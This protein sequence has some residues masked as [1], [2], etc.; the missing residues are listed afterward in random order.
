M[1]SKP[2]SEDIQ[3]KYL[4]RD[5]AWTEIQTKLV[6]PENNS[7][8]SGDKDSDQSY[9][10]EYFSENFPNNKLKTI[11]Q[12]SEKYGISTNYRRKSN[13]SS[14]IKDKHASSRKTHFYEGLNPNQVGKSSA[15]QVSEIKN[16]NYLEVSMESLQPQNLKGSQGC[17]INLNLQNQSIKNAMRPQT[18]N[19]NGQF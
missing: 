4:K 3:R 19:P 14:G 6:H 13:I 2:T 10:D 15:K 16:G 1:K 7:N 17:V 12:V 8:K 11:L 9:E 18:T 5:S